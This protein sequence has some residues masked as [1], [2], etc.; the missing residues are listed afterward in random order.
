MRREMESFLDLLQPDRLP[1]M[2]KRWQ[3]Q[4]PYR[5][6]TYLTPE[7]LKLSVLKS[8]RMVALIEEV[9]FCVA[10]ESKERSILKSLFGKCTHSSVQ[11]AARNATQRRHIRANVREILDEIGLACSMPVIRWSGI[12][13]NRILLSICTGVLVN[14]ASMQR[15][16]ATIGDRPVLYLPSHRSYLDFVLMS[17]ICFAYNLTIPGIAA[18]MDFHGMV[19]IGRL[20]R[21]TCAF[22]MR[23]S[24]TGDPLYWQVFA[25]Y[26]HQ[27]VTAYHT[28]VEFFIEGTR[29]RSLKALPPKIGLLSMALQPLFAGEVPDITIVPI[30]VAYERPLEEQLFAYELLGV[31]KPRESTMALF[32]A[33]KILRTNH[34]RMYI[35]FGEPI[36]SREFFGADLE[37]IKHAQLPVHV[38]HLTRPELRQV[39]DIG[40]HIVVQQQHLIVL[41][42]FNLIA[43]LYNFYAS[44]GEPVDLSTLNAGVL[45]L[46]RFLRTF[47]A[48]VATADGDVPAAIVESLRLH[49]NLF[50]TPNTDGEADTM[51]QLVLLRPELEHVQA[52]TQPADAS[53]GTPTLK[54]HQ[55]A[56]GTLRNAVPVLSLQIH[57]NPCMFW[58]VRPA[59]VVLSVRVLTEGTSA[60]K[61]DVDADTLMTAI[62]QR[63]KQL[64]RIFRDEFVLPNVTVH[65]TVEMLAAQ[66]VLDA[67]TLRCAE[68]RTAELL[69]ST[70]VP[71]L[72]CYL[73]VTRTILSDVNEHGFGERE[74]LVKAQQRAEAALVV[75]QPLVHP[76]CLSLDSVGHAFHSFLAN[77]Y[78]KKESRY[79]DMM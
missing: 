33:M 48:L 27:L 28:G 51:Q 62:E 9:S 52:V 38:Q 68:R 50:R 14:D 5:M 16:K 31:P 15:L 46:A 17:F 7:Q 8:E 22:F 1:R 72:C 12:C 57:C 79:V 25:E 32:K 77:G 18:G 2:T 23:R 78:L 40:R 71:F 30:G 11:H 53:S 65:Q 54:A 26:M 49:D 21:R 41:N 75:G 64:L 19:G 6:D 20:I 61:D 73:Q 69:L 63:T 39:A 74:L 56:A 47:G 59:F 76:Y 55:L 60:F 13:L 29:S 3:P 43:V 67:R 58:L 37:R 24:F 10:G 66:G 45:Q 42:V 35:N 44:V 70:L 34:G 4:V 36:S